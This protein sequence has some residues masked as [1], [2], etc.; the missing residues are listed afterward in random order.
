M[1]M[2]NFWF[3]YVLVPCLILVARVIDVSLDTIRVIMVAK[4]YRKIIKVIKQLNPNALYSIEDVRFVS[5]PDYV[6]VLIFL[7]V[8]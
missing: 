5:G 3:D 2:E 8:C 7:A 6:P 4:G 1:I